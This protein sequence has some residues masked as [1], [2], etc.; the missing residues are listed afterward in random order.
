MITLAQQLDDALA[1][2]DHEQAASIAAEIA[3]PIDYRKA[4]ERIYEARHLARSNPRQETHPMKPQFELSQQK[5]RLTSY[6]PR[7]ELHG[8]D[9]K[10]AATL[11]FACTLPASALAMFS[12]TL[13]AA[14]EAAGAP[15]RKALASHLESLKR[16]AATADGEAAT[17]AAA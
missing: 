5:A 10:P 15:T 16:A 1:A 4:M 7:R 6:T 13:R 2:G 8:E 9:P 11:A 3:N 17:R 12:P 14:W